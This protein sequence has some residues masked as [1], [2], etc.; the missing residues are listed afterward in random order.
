[1]RKKQGIVCLLALLLVVCLVGCGGSKERLSSELERQLLGNWYIKEYDDVVFSFYDDG[2]F[3]AGGETKGTWAVVN[4]DQLKLEMEPDGTF[5]TSIKSLSDG[6]MVLDD[7]EGGEIVLY[8]TLPTDESQDSD[9]E[10]TTEVE[11]VQPVTERTSY[12]LTEQNANLS[13]SY[14]GTGEGLFSYYFGSSS[15]DIYFACADETGKELFR[16]RAVPGED[17]MTTDFSNGCAVVKMKENGTAHWFLV[18][19][20]GGIVWAGDET[21]TKVTG[22]GDGYF[23]VSKYIS[24]FDEKYSQYEVIDYKGNL[25]YVSEKDAPE[26]NYC[27]DNVFLIGETLFTVQNGKPVMWD[28][29][30]VGQLDICPKFINGNAW[31]NNDSDTVMFLKPDGTSWVLPLEGEFVNTQVNLGG[32]GKKCVFRKN[33]FLGSYDFASG[34]FSTAKADYL[35][36]VQSVESFVDDRCVVTLR[37]ADGEQYF[38]VFDG[39]WNEII[40]PTKG[41][42]WSGAYT[43][44]GLYVL[45]GLDVQLYDRDGTL[46]FTFSE[47]RFSKKSTMSD[48]LFSPEP[49]SDIVVMD[50]SGT[51]VG[52]DSKGNVTFDK[53]D[54]SGTV[55]ITN[56][57]RAKIAQ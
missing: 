8:D 39:S 51:F 47:N 30:M 20:T 40:P 28:S 21:V 52:F 23:L 55:D 42:P 6:K 14:T 57:L 37:G 38:A 12:A 50:K 46:S 24:T 5:V 26:C 15:A 1:M 25:I 43:E 13:R 33:G 31:A 3:V 19:T 53:I 18:N 36:K 54:A 45:T 49:E 48:Y 22:E 44:K 4:G 27:G 9:Q 10:V 32:D 29:A 35:D 17:V 41:N 56:A 11:A 7:Q 34:I 2:T 16:F